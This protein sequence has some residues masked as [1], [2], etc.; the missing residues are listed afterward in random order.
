LID[1]NVFPDLGATNRPPMKSP[2]EL[3]SAGR[4][5]SGAGA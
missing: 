3:F 2:Y 5:L 1:W 4:T